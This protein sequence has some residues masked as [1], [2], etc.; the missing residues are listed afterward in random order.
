M[1]YRHAFHAGNFADLVK[2]AGLLELMG[3]MQAASMPIRVVETHAGRGLYDL[4]GEEARRSGEAGL[5]VEVLMKAEDPPA[6]LDALKAVV[7]ALRRQGRPFAYPGSPLLATGALRGQGAYV[8]FEMARAEHEAL[9]IA[10][11]GHDRATSRCGDG[12]AGA[13]GAIDAAVR[14]LL[15]IDPPFERA[16]DYERISICVSECLVHR[17]DT[18][19]LIWTPL[20]DLE[21][22][23]AFLRDLE[24]GP[25]RGKAMLVAETR[26]RPL[27]DPM[28]MNGCALILINAP[29]GLEARLSAICSWVASRCGET[30]LARVWRP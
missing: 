8:G 26:L 6:G 22:F 19:V 10:L 3:L 23:D 14:N 27:T 24:D 9:A 21:T 20:K 30:G 16:D 15:L 25:G 7:A 1:N 17:A 4:G 29:E 2:H 18:H 13:P 28:K 12:F 11:K 5:G